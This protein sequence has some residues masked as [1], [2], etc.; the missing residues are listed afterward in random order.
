MLSLIFDGMSSKNSLDF[1]EKFFCLQQEIIETIMAYDK[2]KRIPFFC[3]CQ[4]YN[5]KEVFKKQCLKNNS[6][7]V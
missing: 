6:E 2:I 4:K 1:S 3:I 7:K 5:T